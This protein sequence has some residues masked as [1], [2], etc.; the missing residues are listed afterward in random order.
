MNKKRKLKLKAMEE[1][2]GKK[3]FIQLFI[4]AYLFLVVGI[5]LFKW[6]PLFFLLLFSYI[7]FKVIVTYKEL[8]RQLEN[9]DKDR[10]RKESIYLSAIDLYY[11]NPINVFG[12]K[13]TENSHINRCYNKLKT[14][15]LLL[16]ITFISFIS[17]NIT[18]SII[19]EY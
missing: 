7:L 5:L 15:L 6:S 16:L 14:F 3:R 8:V 10:F 17:V 19:Y 1:V 9:F 2:V 18:Y 13:L 11:W 4:I 12:F